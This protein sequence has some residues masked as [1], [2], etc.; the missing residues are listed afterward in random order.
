MRRKLCSNFQLDRTLTPITS[1]LRTLREIFTYL[2]HLG[3]RFRHPSERGNISVQTIDCSAS[4]YVFAHALYLSCTSLRRNA[5]RS[6]RDVYET[7]HNVIFSALD[8]A[9]SLC[10]RVKPQEMTFL[11]RKSIC[12]ERE[13]AV[14]GQS[15]HSISRSRF[16]SNLCSGLKVVGGFDNLTYYADALSLFQSHL[17]ANGSGPVAVCPHNVGIFFTIELFS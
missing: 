11:L 17:A 1:L 4:S 6:P 13:L 15:F 14:V 8:Q 16:K 12:Q 3:T 5:I 9:E 2:S 7:T 10:D